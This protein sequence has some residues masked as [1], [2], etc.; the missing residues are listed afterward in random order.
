MQELVPTGKLRVG[1]GVGPVS[2]AFWASK[3]PTT[4]Q[5]KGVTVDLGIDL[6]KKLGVPLAF[7]IYNNSGEVTAAGPL[8]EWDVAFMPMD[9]ERAR[10]V[11]FGPAYFLVESTYLVPAGSTAQTIADVDHPG[12]R[13]LGIEGTTTARSAARSLKQTTLQTVRTVEEIYDALRANKV[14]A[15]ALGK[16]SLESLAASFPGSRVLPGHYQATGVAIA[17]PKNHPAALAYV[18]AYIEEAKA[19]GVVRRALDNTGMKDAAVAPP[20]ERK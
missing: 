5:P 20:A 19:S 9:G 2:S 4:G 1:I 15:V 7:V 17:V 10:M 11:D 13:V 16:E 18:S 3:D 12:S 8:G 6:A 14:D